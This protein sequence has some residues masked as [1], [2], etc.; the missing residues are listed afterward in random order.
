MTKGELKL[1]EY[2]ELV[3]VQMF[4]TRSQMKTILTEIETHYSRLTG[5]RPHE[6]AITLETNHIDIND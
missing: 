5:S 6:I 4:Y 3:K 2:G 1:F